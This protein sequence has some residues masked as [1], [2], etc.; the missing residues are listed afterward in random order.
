MQYGERKRDDQ[1]TK[2]DALTG[3]LWQQV[4]YRQVGYQLTIYYQWKRGLARKIWGRSL[5]EI[6]PYLID[7]AGS[8][9]LLSR[10]GL[11]QLV[12]EQTHD[13]RRMAG[14]HRSAADIA[15]PRG[16]FVY[17]E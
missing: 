10:F 9:P 11:G 4:G 17:P 14:L 12:S 13:R 8:P 7:Q 1:T 2:Y 6:F 3:P 15:V 5:E 16:Q